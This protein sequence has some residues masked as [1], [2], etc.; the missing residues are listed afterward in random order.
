MKRRYCCQRCGYHYRPEQLELGR[1]LRFPVC[2]DRAACAARVSARE[3]D[4]EAARRG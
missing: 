3:A 1:G 2:I 4:R